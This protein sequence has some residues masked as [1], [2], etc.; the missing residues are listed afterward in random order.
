M[1]ASMN[2]INIFRASKQIHDLLN[3]THIQK[4]QYHLILICRMK[5]TIISNISI[6]ETDMAKAGATL[7]CSFF[8]PI[9]AVTTSVWLR[10]VPSHFFFFSFGAGAYT[11]S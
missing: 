9:V 3:F 5:K 8:H 10:D 6:G 11:F 7:G 2:L 4:E 1:Y